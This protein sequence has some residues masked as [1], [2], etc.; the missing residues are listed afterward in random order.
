M[1]SFI[2]YY[3]CYLFCCW[4]D[5]HWIKEAHAPQGSMGKVPNITLQ[6]ATSFQKYWFPSLNLIQVSHDNSDSLLIFANNGIRGFKPWWPVSTWQA[7]TGCQERWVKCDLAE[8][9]SSKYTTTN[10]KCSIVRE[11]D[12][13]HYNATYLNIKFLIVSET[14]QNI[15]KFL[16]W[17]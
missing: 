8:S 5:T 17:T 10:L 1:I 6:M 7:G 14:I 16:R 11:H 12:C 3:L 4:Q 2:I 9:S 13:L 15:I